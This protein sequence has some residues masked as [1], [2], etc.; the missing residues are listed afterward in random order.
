MFALLTKK[1]VDFYDFS[2]LQL[3]S[4]NFLQIKNKAFVKNYLQMP[5]F[6]IK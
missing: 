3:K 1:E 4:C 5:L 2:S 6:V